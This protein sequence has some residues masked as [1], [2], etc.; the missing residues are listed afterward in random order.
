MRDQF[1]FPLTVAVGVGMFLLALQPFADRPPTGP[2]SGGGRNAQDIT[3]SGTELHRLLPGDAGGLDIVDTPEGDI[4]RITRLATQVYAN[5]RSGP[6][7]VLAA[8]VEFAMQERP[9]EVV[10]EARSAG[11]FAASQFQ[12]DFLARPGE[13]LGWQTFDLTSEFKPYAFTYTTPTR[14][15]V[16]GYDYLGVRP[17]TPDKRRTFEVRS[18]RIHVVG[19]RGG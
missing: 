1:F 14:G 15:D 12:A 6:H 13:E 11:E 10:I 7:L 17:V 16:E 18:V 9:I 4:L 19:E 5:P 3:V 8:D 2:V